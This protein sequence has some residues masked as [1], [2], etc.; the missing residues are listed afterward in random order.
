MTTM[1]RLVTAEELW[2]L[3]GSER[4]ELVRGE[5]RTIAPGGFEHGRV[6]NNAAFLLTSFVRSRNAG[7]VVT[8]ETGFLLGRNPDLVRAPDAAFVNAS[9]VVP[10]QIKYYDG[11]PDLAVEVISPGDTLVEVEEKVDDYLNAGTR[12]VWVINP[13]RRTVTVY[14]PN[15]HPLI[16][17]END[18]LDGDEVLP[19]FQCVV[20][21]VFT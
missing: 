18:S 20:A 16:L 17:R 19:G 10:S 13:R 11:A 7:T 14:E 12:L 15:Q 6:G 3:P 2:E 21:E 4:R 1:P 5:V 9:R 8:A